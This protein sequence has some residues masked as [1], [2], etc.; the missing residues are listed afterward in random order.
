MFELPKLDYPYDALE[1]YIDQ[2]TVEIHYGKHHQ[3]YTN[4][5]NEVLKDEPDLQKKTIEELIK[6]ISAID[7]WGGNR[8]QLQFDKVYAFEVLANE[9]TDTFYMV[10]EGGEW[11]ILK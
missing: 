1:P 10:N 11:K 3:T 8:Y 6:N 4:N 2:K 9:K 5:L 7:S